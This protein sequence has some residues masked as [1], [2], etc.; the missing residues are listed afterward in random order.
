MG[1]GYNTSDL[2]CRILTFLDR[3]STHLSAGFR[4]CCLL[5]CSWMREIQYQ[6]LFV[7]FFLVALCGETGFPCHRKDNCGTFD[8]GGGRF[9]IEF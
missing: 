5:A 8:E 9:D 6:H 4:C 3:F 7:P 2:V 1:P